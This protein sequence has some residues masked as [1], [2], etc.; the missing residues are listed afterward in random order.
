MGLEIKIRKQSLE[1]ID[2]RNIRKDEP[3]VQSEFREYKVLFEGG[4]LNRQ[5]SN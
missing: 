4:Y 3:T 1:F 5:N 2:W